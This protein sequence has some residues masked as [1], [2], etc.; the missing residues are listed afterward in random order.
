VKLSYA[1]DIALFAT[2]KVR[3][4]KTEKENSFLK[5][6]ERRLRKI[7]CFLEVL[8]AVNGQAKNSPDKI[9]FIYLGRHIE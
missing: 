6:Q 9:P 4:I 8:C 2:K 7:D 1:A 5:T 3:A